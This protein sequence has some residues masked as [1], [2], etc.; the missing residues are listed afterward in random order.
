MNNIDNK[1]LKFLNLF[2]PDI[3]ADI[4]CN[5]LFSSSQRKTGLL[6]IKW[7]GHT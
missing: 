5:D 1:R 3:F 6:I 4:A 2:L 7:S